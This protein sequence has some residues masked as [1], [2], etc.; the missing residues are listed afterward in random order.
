MLMVRIQVHPDTCSRQLNPNPYHLA[1]GLPFL[2]LLA[3][4]GT[5]SAS[6]AKAASSPAVDHVKDAGS[7][8]VSLY[9]LT[10]LQ[11]LKDTQM[12]LKHRET[13][14]SRFFK[15]ASKAGTAVQSQVQGSMTIPLHT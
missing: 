12:L 4:R 6:R 15:S 1:A 7:S 5:V 2:W 13:S 3:W 9:L 8:C 10:P 14:A 11:T